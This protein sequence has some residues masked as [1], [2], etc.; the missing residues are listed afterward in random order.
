[1]L[2]V[3]ASNTL[4]AFAECRSF[5]GDGCTPTGSRNRTYPTSE[6]VRVPCMKRSNDS[7]R[8]WGPLSVVTEV[9][10]MYPTVVLLDGTLV[11]HYATWPNGEN[12]T[13]PVVQQLVSTDLGGSWTAPMIVH[14]LPSAFPGGCKG[15]VTPIGRIIF[16][17]YWPQ[18]GHT[19]PKNYSKYIMRVW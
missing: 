16:A 17:G 12:Y 10:G 3:P 8:T 9:H 6:K 7:G 1:M 13:N 11:M 19:L 15:A 18:G 14:G 4:L 5:I 2:Q